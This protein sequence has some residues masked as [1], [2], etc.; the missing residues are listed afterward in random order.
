MLQDLRYAWR[1][2]R[3]NPGLALT[4]ALTLGICIGANTTV[5]SLIDS[6]LIRP[7]PFPH[8]E[9]LYWLTERMGGNQRAIGVGADYYSLREQNR[10]F[11]DV[12][13]YGTSAVNWNGREKPEQ[14]DVARVTPSFFHVLG[15]QPLRGRDLAEEEQGVKA[16]PV[17]VLSYGFW[18]DRLA[19]DPSVIGKTILLDGLAHAV[20]GVMPQGFDYPK[21]TRLWEPL[22]MDEASQRPRSPSRPMRLVSIFARVRAGV[23]EE[24]LRTELKRLT[25]NIRAE[26]PKAFEGAGFLNSMSIS[27]IPLQRQ[28]TGDL[29]PALLVMSGS[30]GLVLLIACA[31]LASLLLARATGRRRELAVRMA[32]GSGKGRIFKQVLLESVIFALPGGLA[33]G[34]LAVIAVRVLNVVKPMALENYPSISIDGKT[35]AFSLGVTLLTGLIFGIVPALSAA[36]IHIQDALKAGG[37]SQTGSG[38]AA[39]MRQMLV[40][41]ELGMSL[42][43]MIA[44]ALLARSFIKLS[45]VPLGFEPANLLTLRFNLKGEQYAGGRA[46]SAY[47][48]QVLARVEQLPMVR[49]A[50]VSTD[51]P[52]SGEQPYSEMRFQVEGRARAALAQQPSAYSTVVSPGFFRTLGVP[53]RSGRAFNSEDRSRTG[54]KMVVNE[55]LVREVFEHEDPLGKRI[56]GATIVG[57]VG[58]IRGS[59]LGATPMPL[60][61]YCSC[62][63]ES[64]FENQMALFVRTSADPHKA[65]RDIEGQAYSV[66]R[67]EPVFDVRTMEERLADSLAPQRFHLM[68][69]GA[70]AGIALVLSALGVFGTMTYLVARRRREIGIRLAVGA[71]PAHIVRMIVG[72]SALLVLCALAIGLVGAWS[73]T[74]YLQ[75]MLYGV[76]SSDA[77]SF[78]ATPL[79]LALIALAAAYLPAQQASGTDPTAA[80]REE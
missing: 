64:P 39:R 35:M 18:R 52:L 10:V 33:G 54:V 53:L 79:L 6:I 3:L 12:G 24:Q 4:A 42:V 27:A 58:D 78:V 80:L 26:Y 66:D 1:G 59:Y 16:P 28:L 15:A 56:S 43:L 49:S 74:R 17:I 57:V 29:R 37:G 47:Y 60:V 50:A 70:F 51:V 8:S 38:W 67:N 75:S 68:L 34:L 22:D 19:S 69:A 11:Q 21:G 32:L 71:Q 41:F 65:T 45:E 7:L 14:L 5:F 55:A 61:Y 62:Q 13:A 44:A 36:G 9:R 72:E 73:L 46:Q 31:N 63:S 76:T 2:L 20:I 30:V 23:S 48:N 25:G 40:V 77:V